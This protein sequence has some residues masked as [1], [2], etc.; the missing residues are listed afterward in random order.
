[1]WSLV[2]SGKNKKIKRCHYL[3]LKFPFSIVQW[4]NLSGFKPSWNTVKVKGMLQYK[5]HLTLNI[6]FIS[7]SNEHF[8]NNNILS[9]NSLT[10]TIKKCTKTCTYK[11]SILVPTLHTPHA[12]V[13]SSLVADAWL[14]WHSIPIQ[15]THY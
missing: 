4:A 12:T 7:I 8:N 1:M 11:Y 15:I 6:I 5:T 13:H 3:L 10:I 14:A 2:S 9:G